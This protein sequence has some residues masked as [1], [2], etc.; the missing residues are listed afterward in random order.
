MRK[1]IEGFVGQLEDAFS[2]GEKVQFS[3]PDKKLSNVFFVSIDKS[4][5]TGKSV[6]SQSPTAPYERFSSK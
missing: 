1:H 2:I 4:L 5:I 6:L 3:I